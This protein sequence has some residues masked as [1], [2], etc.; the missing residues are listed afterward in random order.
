MWLCSLVNKGT[1]KS[2]TMK[3]IILSFVT[4]FLISNPSFAFDISSYSSEEKKQYKEIKKLKEQGV[5]GKNFIDQ[6]YWIKDK[7]NYYHN[8]AATHTGIEGLRMD[9]K[10]MPILGTKGVDHNWGWKVG[11]KRKAQAAFSVIGNG[12]I[13]NG[14]M[15]MI[16]SKKHA[17]HGEEFYQMTGS[18]ENC[19]PQYWDY[20]ECA[21]YGGSVHNESR[22]KNVK[23][24]KLLSKEGGEAWMH[25]ATKP[26]RNVLFP[27]NPKRRFHVFQ[28]H[29]QG[30]TITLMIT[31]VYGRLI[32]NLQ[33]SEPSEKRWVLK[34]YNINEFN[35]ADEWTSITMHLV[36]SYKSKKGK[37]TVWVDGN[38][39]PVVQYSGKTTTKKRKSCFIASGIYVNGAITA[40]DMNTTQDSTVWADAVAIAKTKEDLLELINKEDK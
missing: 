28:C 27:Y 30:D 19:N 2:I 20:K 37:F 26:V 33:F 40:R 5:T 31:Y 21:A 6:K 9:I 34:K 39:E 10:R 24:N 18:Y 12:T 25:I 23:W 16:K 29:P 22:E 14:E 35:G 11:K 7:K 8:I 1:T 3:K 32:A 17:W 4:F 38:E 36:N 13:E 15:G